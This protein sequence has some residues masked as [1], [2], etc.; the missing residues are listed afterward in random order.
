MPRFYITTAIDYV[1]GTPH[2]G[3]AYEKV[4]A[5]AIARW[6]RQKGDATYFLT[7]TDEHGQKIAR[8]AAAAGKDPKTFVDE[9][10]QS[11]VTAWAA[12]DVAYDQFFRTT[13]RRHEMAVQELFRQ[14]RDPSPMQRTKLDTLN[15]RWEDLWELSRM[16]VER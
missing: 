4:L 2:L 6:H 8:T 11:F 14:I 16:Y 7:G 12:L 13:D 5:D 3:H 15:G 1:N 10:S 9:L